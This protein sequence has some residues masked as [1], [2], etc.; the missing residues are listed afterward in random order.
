MATYKQ[1][2]K[3]P[4]VVVGEEPAKTTMRKANVSVANVR[5]QDYPP[6]KTSGRFTTASPMENK[7]GTHSVKTH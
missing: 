1:A 2:T 4:N 5:S 3:K 6:M 7:N